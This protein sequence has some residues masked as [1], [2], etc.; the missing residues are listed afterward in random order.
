MVDG[1]TG[2]ARREMTRREA[3]A[4]LAKAGAASC[5]L[6]CMGLQAGEGE[7][8]KIGSLFDFP[9]ASAKV[10][11]GVIVSRT[12]QGMAAFSNICTHKRHV[13]EVDERSGAIFCSLHGSGF[14]LTGKPTNGPATRALKWYHIEVDESGLVWL[15]TSKSVERGTWAPLPKWAQQKE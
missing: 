5:A 7:R 6:T 13:L 4:W 15:D 1:K 11:D 3:L 12:S 10:V 9:N 8:K 14:D 2:M